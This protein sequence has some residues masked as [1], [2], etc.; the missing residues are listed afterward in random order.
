MRRPNFLITCNDAKA[1]NQV[2][3]ACRLE[4]SNDAK[5]KNNNACVATMQQLKILENS[6]DAKAKNNNALLLENKKYVPKHA[7]VSC[8]W[9][10]M[11]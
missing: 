5:A 8:G 11:Q 4:K 2:L 9:A 3:Y 7:Q 10:S 6:N 1:K